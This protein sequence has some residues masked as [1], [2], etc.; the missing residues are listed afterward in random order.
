MVVIA[1]DASTFGGFGLGSG[2]AKEWTDLAAIITFENKS[3]TGTIEARDGGGY[4]S[5]GLRWEVK[6][7]YQV[8]FFVDVR[9]HTYRAYVRAPGAST[10]T[11]IGGTLAFRT[12]QRAVTML[13]A[14][15]VHASNGAITVCAL[16]IS[17]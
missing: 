6:Q 12:D 9:T 15:T 2:A 4:V 10:E 7:R 3:D 1:S 13:D 5:S 14:M 8:R 11:Q 17:N 16:E